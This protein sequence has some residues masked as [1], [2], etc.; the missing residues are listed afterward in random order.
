MRYEGRNAGRADPILSLVGECGLLDMSEMLDST[1]KASCL[2]LQGS[3]CW[4]TE[5]GTGQHNKMKLCSMWYAWVMLS[6]P[7]EIQG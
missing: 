1:A 7:G 2:P 5:K 4:D 6:S 3:C